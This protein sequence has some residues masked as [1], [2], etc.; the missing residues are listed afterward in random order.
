[1]TIFAQTLIIEAVNLGDL[2]RLVVAT[3]NRDAVR[4]AH[5]Q[6]NE[7]SDRLDTVMTAV[8]VISHEQIIGVRKTAAQAEK[9][10][11]V[12]EL[13]VY[14]TANR[15]RHA[16]RLHILLFGEDFFRLDT[17]LLDLRLG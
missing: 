4:I 15:D 9:F 14:V 6:C 13:T 10:T 12:V 11:K 16:H 5:L 3:Q 1:M 7:K 8:D 2:A 17:E